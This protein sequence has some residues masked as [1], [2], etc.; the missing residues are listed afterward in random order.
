MKTNIF[1]NTPDSRK[2]NENFAKQFGGK[3]N[4]ENYSRE[5]LEDMRNKL[6]TRVSQ[7]EGSAGYN[8]LLTNETYQ[9]DKAMLQ[10]LNTRIKEMLGE[11]IKKLKDKMVELSEA[12]K[13][14]RAPKYAKKAKGTK[15]NDQDG[16][17]KPGEFDDVQVARMV[18]GGVPKKKAIAKATSDKFNETA[19]EEGFDDLMKATK[20]RNAAKPSGG[21]GVKK[22]KAYGGTAQK[23][24]KEPAKKEK[25]VKE[26]V[27]AEEEKMSAGKK[28][29]T[30][31]NFKRNVRMVNES[32]QRMIA[33][34]EE[35]KA[36]AI[37]AA[38]D[39]VNDF[40]TWM[41]RVGQYQTKAIIELSDA[42]RADFG[43]QQAEAFKQAVA[44]AL[45]ATLETLT[46]QR[47][48]ISN[49]VAVLAGEDVPP[50][51]QMG[52]E[53][54]VGPEEPGMEPAAP[55][56]L[57]AEPAAD[58][59]A[60]SDAAAGGPETS[61]REMRESRFRGT[62][63]FKDEALR[64]QLA[65]IIYDIY[66]GAMA[67]QDMIDDI[68]DELGDLF[69]Q[70]ETS[71]DRYLKAAYEIMRDQGSNAGGD[72]RRMAN[73]AKQALGLLNLKVE[74][75]ESKFARKLAESHSIISKLAK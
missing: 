51:E 25:K 60:A 68:S 34:D 65:N 22:G 75:N 66:Q 36:K 16:D 71:G 27:K 19:V 61:G 55:D 2:L 13:G 45:A 5:Q 29:K 64:K 44:P 35:G 49:A 47:E 58:E 42:I 43:L 6:R 9:K 33:E 10:L 63:K 70:V 4:L 11:D 59:F 62:P 74:S 8:D 15:G 39:M 73:V 17:G 7:Q 3:V 57:N 31:E 23:D 38:S 72:P 32:L 26:A 48:T 28:K 21:A 54:E 20:E 24:E 12:K 53:P 56:E 30:N 40:T 18:A 52:M 14:V 69:D 1:F 37:T 50:G 41:Q 46:Q 67:G